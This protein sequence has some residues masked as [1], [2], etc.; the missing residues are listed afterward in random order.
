MYKLV[1][2]VLLFWGDG[3]GWGSEIN[4]NWA[5]SLKLLDETPGPKL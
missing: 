4:L 2:V 5:L 3:D 1:C